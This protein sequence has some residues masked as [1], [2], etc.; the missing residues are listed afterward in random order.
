MIIDKAMRVFS[1]PTYINDMSKIKIKQKEL[2]RFSIG[3]TI[4]FENLEL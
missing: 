2:M 1:P 3:F 4:E